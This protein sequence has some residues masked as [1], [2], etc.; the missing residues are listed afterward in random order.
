MRGFRSVPE[1]HIKQHAHGQACDLDSVPSCNLNACPQSAIS[2]FT[3]QG[4]ADCTS[5][6]ATTTRRRA[7]A[8]QACILQ[9]KG[10]MPSKWSCG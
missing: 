2:I 6:Q 8:H 3:V 1:Q 4:D 9:M 7:Q 5:S 10:I